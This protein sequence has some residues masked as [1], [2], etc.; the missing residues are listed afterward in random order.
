MGMKISGVGE[1][2][3]VRIKV[4]VQVKQLVKGIKVKCWGVEGDT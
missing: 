3:V 1:V 4:S 2:M